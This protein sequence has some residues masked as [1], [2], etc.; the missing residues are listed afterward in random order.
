MVRWVV[1]IAAILGGTTISSCGRDSTPPPSVTQV[2]VLD[3]N[4]YAAELR[5]TY[6]RLGW[7]ADYRP[8]VDRLIAATKPAP[9]EQVQQGVSRQVLAVVNSCAW[10]RSWDAGR[11]RGDTT[12][13]A[14]AL[15]VLTDVLTKYPPEQDLAGRSF[16]RQAAEHAKAG[17]PDLA[18]Q[19]VT[20]N[21]EST[22]WAD[23]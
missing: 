12:A 21:C 13:A 6:P 1:V 2:V 20:A 23:R 17:N 11:E 7:P 16:V 9:G 3:E 4:G 22:A 10:Y 18:R 5:E 8:D 14:K 15:A 19:Y